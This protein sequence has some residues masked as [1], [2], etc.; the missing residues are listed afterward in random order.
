MKSAH[1]VIAQAETW[2][3]PTYPVPAV[4]EMPMFA[5]LR[6][7]QGTSGNPYPSRV[8]QKVDREHRANRNY[9][10][11]RLENDY[12]RVC[13]LPELGGRIFEAY[14]KINDYHF[15]YRQ[16][17]I[18]PALIG[19]FGSWIS[20]GMEFNWPFHHRPSTFMPVDYEIE[21]CSDGSAICWLSECDPADR[22]RG[23]VGIVLTPDAS[24]FETRMRVS[25][26][27][28]FA[29]SFLWWENAAVRVH[30]KYR[31]IFPP[32]VTWAHHHY[33]RSHTTF[34]IAEGQYG[35]ERFDKPTDISWHG[36]TR[37]ASSYF[38]A[39]SE[40]DFFGG[41]DYEKECGTMHIADHHVSPGKKMFTWG[42]GANA[43]NWEASLTD[44][45]GPYAELMAGSYT[46][47]QPDFTWLMPYETKC[48]SQ[49]WYPLRG[50]RYVTAATLHCAV[51][52][53]RNGVDSRCGST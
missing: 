46:D 41:Y 28:P 18:K 24:Y 21:R 6:G 32:D 22:T 5:E 49:F 52:V 43:D 19:A 38:A 11:V 29:H 8:V 34:P 4:E 25:N 48:F 44:S 15:L 9:T 26:R 27:T 42:Y 45:D 20:G 30:E 47:D 3:I 10:V 35:A 13:I 7:H 36:N 17:V 39:P 14:D 53:E 50:V 33:D 2:T 12:I 16:H 23:T 37:T 31:L 51:A 40:F 1:P